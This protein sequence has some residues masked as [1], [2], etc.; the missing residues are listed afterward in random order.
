MYTQPLIKLSF[1]AVLFRSTRRGHIYAAI[2]A[3]NYRVCGGGGSPDLAVVYLDLV[4]WIGLN[5]LDCGPKGAY[6]IPR[7]M[8]VAYHRMMNIFHVH[9]S[10]ADFGEMERDKAI[11]EECKLPNGA[12]WYD[13]VSGCP[14]KDRVMMEAISLSHGLPAPDYDLDAL[15]NKL[16]ENYTNPRS[17]E[18]SVF[19][20]LMN[21]RKACDLARAVHAFKGQ[22][23][24]KV[25]SDL[26]GTYNPEEEGWWED[27]LRIKNVV[28]P[29][30]SWGKAWIYNHF[31]SNFDTS[32]WF[33]EAG[34]VTRVV[35][36]YEVYSSVLG[37]T[38]VDDFEH[39]ELLYALKR[40]PMIAKGWSPESVN[41]IFSGEKP[42]PEQPTVVAPKCE[43]SKYGHPD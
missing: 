23:S 20:E 33:Y 34:D 22:V 41:K 27:A 40:A 21:F 11:A 28:P 25:R 8:K 7:A 38:E 12:S 13:K 19:A 43:T 32:Q 3:E 14:I 26:E 29:R 15:F 36:K 37:M 10:A 5:I 2:Y 35:P 6:K 4:K 17:Y 24:Y 42:V 1:R 30:D 39:N 18:Q 31:T 9:D 16:Y